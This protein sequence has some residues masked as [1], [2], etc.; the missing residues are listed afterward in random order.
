M[1]FKSLHEL[2]EFL[3]EF[4]T[5]IRNKAFV[6]KSDKFAN[7]NV[8]TKSKEKLLSDDTISNLYF[9]IRTK[10]D[11]FT[12]S[13]LY[14]Y[15]LRKKLYSIT[16]GKYPLYSL[17][18]AR[19]KANEYNTILQSHT[20][21]ESHKDLKSYLEN[22]TITELGFSDVATQWFNIKNIRQV[23]YNANKYLLKTLFKRFTNMPLDKITR[24]D[25]KDFLQEYQNKGKLAHSKRLFNV[26]Q[27]IYEYALSN[28]YVATSPFHRM[29]YKLLFKMPTTTHHKS[30]NENELKEFLE[31]L[32]SNNPFVT[33]NTSILHNKTIY[34]YMLKFLVYVPLRIKNIVLLEWSE[35]DFQE[36]MLRIPAKK[37]KNHKKFKLPLST[38]ALHILEVMQEYKKS[39][40]VFDRDLIPIKIITIQL[41]KAFL[42][43]MNEFKKGNTFANYIC[44]QKLERINIKKDSKELQDKDNTKTLES[45]S[46]T[47]ELEN[48]SK[49]EGKALG[50]DKKLTIRQIATMFEVNIYALKTYIAR[51]KQQYFNNTYK[52]NLKYHYAK[53]DTQEVFIT[54]ID[55]AFT[56]KERLNKYLSFRFTPHC[57]RSTFSTILYEKTPLHAIDF[58]VIEMC[59][60]HGIGNQII[61]SYNHSERMQERKE[62]MQFWANYVDSLIEVRQLKKLRNGS[63]E[64]NPSDTLQF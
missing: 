9:H 48:T 56:R 60:S 44:N 34:Y 38:Q 15:S 52:L 42:Y 40:Y 24:Q 28:D 17:Q 2:K 18:E 37:M 55:T 13:F 19:A 43:Y 32:Q 36:K 5:E 46:N 31:F 8:N 25:I 10:K 33:T 30:F 6:T 11:S 63:F 64:I 35:I 27:S 20:F 54:I 58:I 50:S 4:E 12:K 26:L 57:M 59:L 41:H 53:Y 62:L 51:H 45:A 7:E 29:Q 14:R 47:Q 49:D 22:M 39:N 16:L 21:R 61:A 1:G 3:K 23:T